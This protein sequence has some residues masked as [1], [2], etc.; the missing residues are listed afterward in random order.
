MR[1]LDALCIALIAKLANRMP[2]GRRAPLMV[3]IGNSSPPI[4]S[5]ILICA[6]SRLYCGPTCPET[7]QDVRVQW[8]SL[9]DSHEAIRAGL[10]VGGRRFGAWSL[11][12]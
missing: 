4:V 8:A 11:G 5:N 2:S 6:S 12:V 7:M 3:R 1:N 9:L 10:P